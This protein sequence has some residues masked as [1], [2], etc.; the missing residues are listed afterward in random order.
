MSKGKPVKT[1]SWDFGDGSGP[2]TYTAPPFNYTYPKSGYFYPSLTVTDEDGCK[3]T[4]TNSY[5]QVNGPNAD[6][7][8]SANLVR[9]GGEVWF[10]N[11]TTETGGYATYEWD[12]GDGTTSTDYSPNKIYDVKG[13][14]TV[15]LL[16]RDNNGCVDSMKK[17]IKVSAVSADFTFT[18]S[19]VNNS[20]CP[21]VI[22]RFTNTSL[23]YSSS[24]WDFGDG[25]F[26]TLDNPAHTYTYAGKYKVKL[27]VTGDAGTEDEFEQ[28]VEVKG[29]YA[30]I[31]TSANGGCLTKEIEFTVTAVNAVNFAWDFTDGVV[32]ETTASAIKHI[33]K[34]PGVYKPRLILSDAAGCKGTAFLDAP[35]VIDKLDVKLISTPAYV[36]DKDWITFKPQFNSYS[37][38]EL[39]E[40]AT[41]QWTFDAALNAQDDAS[42]NPTFYPDQQKEYAF[43]LTTTTAYGCTQTVNATVPVYPRPE[44]IVS[45]PLQACQ[46]A[47]V[48]FSGNV[49]VVND[50][51]WKWEFGNG[52]TSTAQNPVNQAFPAGPAEAVLIVSSKDGCN[53]TAHHAIN[54]TPTPVV[55]AASAAAFVCLGNSTTLSAGGGTRYQWTP[56][57]G[58]NDP[59]SATPVAAPEVSTEY[60]VTVTDANGCTNTDA[61]NIRVAQPFTIQATPD[62][63]LCLGDPLPLW[64]NG[65]HHYV[66]K[67]TGLND[68]DAPNPKATLQ[69]PGNYTYD[70]TGYD[71][72]GC[73]TDEDIVAIK[74]Q[75]TP[76][77]NAGPDRVV[78][79]GSPVTLGGRGSADIIRWTWTPAT[80]L[81]CP[82]CPAPAALPNLT[83]LYTLEVENM[84]GC[85][86]KDEVLVKVV[87]DQGSVTMPT[88][89]TPIKTASMNG[90]IQK[91]AVL[92]K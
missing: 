91:A 11:N 8:P 92:R 57:L 14:Y 65:A 18:T 24:Y 76:V 5:L 77:S 19:F 48:S 63:T 44:A 29:P 7:N 37:I 49:S 60:Q 12:F 31:A 35:I 25:S 72:D 79:S 28:E 3:S 6:F 39:K 78:M 68:T 75:P 30:T 34:D 26:S 80:K 33:F 47:P 9:P 32:T 41:Y 45:G 64:A 90:F 88:A 27:K 51:T 59:Q 87:C 4:A 54:I 10:Y 82:T 1:W 46:D 66:W 40:D 61:V 53:D 52:S 70:V 84:F 55:K 58:L 85:K 2:K 81:D 67:G 62:T 17:Q 38:D 56:A 83:T 73:F 43:T 42:A 16:A 36:C 71:A 86:A 15:R 13:V 69:A 89:I 22:A 21:P 20:G 23:N 50:V 74:V